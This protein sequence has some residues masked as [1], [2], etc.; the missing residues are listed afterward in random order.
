MIKIIAEIIGL[1][2]SVF[3]SLAVDRKLLCAEI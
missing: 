2:L 1:K 3:I